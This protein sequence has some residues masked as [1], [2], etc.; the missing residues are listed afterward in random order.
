VDVVVKV[1]EDDVAHDCFLITGSE[2]FEGLKLIGQLEVNIK[3]GVFQNNLKRTQFRVEP[4]EQKILPLLFI[5][6]FRITLNPN[7]LINISHNQ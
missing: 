7:V 3:L 5:S 2:C 6:N 1:E 4:Y